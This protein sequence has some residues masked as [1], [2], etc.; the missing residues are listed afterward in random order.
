MDSLCEALPRPEVEMSD[1][2]EQLLDT[3]DDICARYNVSEDETRNVLALVH[4]LAQAPEAGPQEVTSEEAYLAFCRGR[5]S[6]EVQ[7]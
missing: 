2:L 3:I 6:N 7:H 5:Y 1:D 4:R